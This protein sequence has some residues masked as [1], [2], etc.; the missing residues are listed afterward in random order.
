MKAML[1]AWS[2]SPT[3]RTTRDH[4]ALVPAS[5]S[6][7]PVD[8]KVLDSLRRLQK[9]QRSDIVQQVIKLFFKGAESLLKDLE[10]GATN[11]DASL[12]HQA[13]HALKSVSANI[14]AIALSSRCREL[15][16]MAQSGIV[17]DAAPIVRAIL[18]DYRTAEILLS[19]RF[20]KV[21]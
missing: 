2:N 15:E 11:H 19:D 16:A 12:L 10:R 4:L 7:E 5:V 3:L 17:S 21:A 14:G 9:E 8:Y 13:S 6:P 18:E 20:Q 1:T